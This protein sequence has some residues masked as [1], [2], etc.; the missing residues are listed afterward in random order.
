MKLMRSSKFFSKRVQNKIGFCIT[1]IRS[2]HGGEFENHAF[3]NFCNENDISHNFSSLRTPQQNGVVERKNR[4]LQEIA[5]TMFLESGLSK[6]FWAKI[7]N[8]TCY[9]QNRVF[10]RLIIKKTTYELWKGRK[11]NIS[12]FHVFEFECFI[13]NTKDKLSKFDPG[14]FLRYSSMSKAYRIYNKKTQTMEETIHL[15]FKEKKKD[16]DQKVQDLE[17]EM[18]NLSLN[19]DDRNQQSLQIATRNGS[20]DSDFPLHQHVSDDISEVLEESPIKRRYSGTRELRDV[21]QN[22]IISEPSQGVRTRFSLR[23]ES[24]LALI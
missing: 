12:Y 17:K 19:H 13:L 8:I 10:L 6:S 24:N 9:I 5:R 1:S 4:S 21:S 20:E 2:D 7:V 16:V 22:Q 23:T 11:P 3:E 14:V 15:T 18:E